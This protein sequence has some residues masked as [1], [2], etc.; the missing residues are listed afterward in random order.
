MENL[1][2]NKIIDANQ[3]FDNRFMETKTLYLY[4]FQTLP[5][6]NF[7]NRIDGEKAFEAF[8]EKFSALIENVHTY[9]WYKHENKKFQFDRTVII[10]KNH[11]LV[12]FDNDYCEILHNGKAD[13]FLNEFTAFLMSFKERE[14][15]Q[16]SE[17]NIV[18]RE[19][20]GLDLKTVEVQKTKLD[21]SLYYEDD[22]KEVNE[23]IQKRLQQKKDKGIILLH[24]LPG[25][26]KTTYLRYLIGRIKKRILFLSPSI[27]GNLMN[28]EFIDLLMDNPNTV[29][30]IEDAEQILMDRKFTN[31]SSVSGLLNISDGLLADFLNVQLICTFNS[32]LTMIDKALLRKGRLIANY[33]FGRL[34]IAKG[35]RLSDH[36][37]FKSVIKRPMTVSEICNQHEKEF[38]TDTV[39][40]LGFSRRVDTE[41]QLS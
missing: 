34:S 3:V 21:I 39:K 27:A 6:V 19:S 7:I 22:F 18:I 28:P 40:V 10:L 9:R 15:R 38:H 24:G 17:I 25:T 12:E 2:N 30:V 33:E 20:G 37:G 29:L 36:L 41:L 35:Q 1:N 23:I 16:P 26:G 14:K 11:C 31:D 8:A 4:H 5:N 13:I 32:P